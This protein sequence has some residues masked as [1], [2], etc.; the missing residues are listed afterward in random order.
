MKRNLILALLFCLSAVVTNAQKGQVWPTLTRQ[1]FEF[2]ENA[3]ITKEYDVEDNFSYYLF[4]DNNE[5]IHC[6]N[7]ITS[8]YKIMSRDEQEKYTD[9]TVVSEV[10]NM[11]T[12]RFSITDQYVAIYS[13]K[14]YG[15]YY[16][17]AAPYLTKVFDN[18]NK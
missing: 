17:V 7:T 11:Y 13:D 18:L 16:S 2:D 15:I 14:G 5:F 10:G 4:I 3:E 8:L 6:T 1:D 9:Y 12:F